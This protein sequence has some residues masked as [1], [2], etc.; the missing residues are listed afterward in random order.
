MLRACPRFKPGTGHILQ[1]KLLL[2]RQDSRRD[3]DNQVGGAFGFRFAG[4]QP[5]EYRDITQKRYFAGLIRFA[6]SQ[7]PT[8][9]HGLTVF[10]TNE[11]GSGTSGGIFG[12]V[13]A[14]ADYIGVRRLHVKGYIP[15]AVYLRSNL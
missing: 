10:H 4:E 3:K 12:V 13:E 11:R 5:T 15:F 2:F 6:G 1:N 9:N 8:D 7:Q 14:G